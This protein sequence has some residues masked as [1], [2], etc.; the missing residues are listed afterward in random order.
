[1]EAEQGAS[2]SALSQAL[3]ELPDTDVD[4]AADLE[5][6]Q[7]NQPEIPAIMWPN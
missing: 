2:W 6:V 5:E 7:R 3:G 4:F 1:M